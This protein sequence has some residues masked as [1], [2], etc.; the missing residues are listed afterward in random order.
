MTFPEFLKTNFI[1]ETI[2]MEKSEENKSLKD[3]TF[4][5]NPKLDFLFGFYGGKPIPTKQDKFAPAKMFFINEDGSEEETK[6]FYKKKPDE[7]SMQEFVDEM[8][9]VS[10]IAF[11]NENIIQKPNLVEVCIS[12]S[13]TA[14][15]FKEVDLDNLCKAVLDSLNGVAFEDDSQV[16][17]LIANKHIHGMQ[18]NAIFVGITKLTDKKKGIGGDFWLFREE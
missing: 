1:D 5:Q 2:K 15:R 13:V 12:I 18:V 11:N 6:D 8:R 14:K 17:S 9:K 7:K 16:S 3:T 10:S 4:I